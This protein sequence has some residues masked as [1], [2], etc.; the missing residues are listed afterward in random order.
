MNPR[1]AYAPASNPIRVLLVLAAMLVMAAPAAAQS[2]ERD[3]F[4]SVLDASDAPVLTLGA[5]DFIVREDGRAREVLRARH[6]SDPF[7]LVVLVDTS[8]AL[9]TQISDVRKALEG[10]VARMREQARIS[11][12]GFGERPTVL[13]DSTNSQQALADGI[14]RIFPITG[15]G[16]YVLDAVDDVL[17]GIEKSKPERPVIV[18]VWAGG[19][20]FGNETHTELVDKLVAT[21][22]AFHVIAIGAGVPRDMF[23]NEG[24]V[25]E[26]L[27]DRGTAAT[28]GRRRNV[29]SS[30]ALPEELN[31]LASELLG[32]YRITFARPDAL[33]PPKQTE[34]A[35]RP[36][37][38]TARGL[39]VPVRRPAER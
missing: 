10:F 25:R 1:L 37:G 32:Q 35:V 4:V 8:Q 2:V 20:E 29:L 17:R 34:V 13:A 30:M 24:R 22:T 26:N 12:V 15:A 6:A 28:G 38:L 19:R 16:A 9:S 18:V 39:L 14:G 3:M 7:D 5:D 11:I 21:G 27:F 36:A 23:T 33:I 31:R